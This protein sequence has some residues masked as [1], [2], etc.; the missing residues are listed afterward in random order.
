MVENQTVNYKIRVSKKA[1]HLQLR[2]APGNQ[3]E[4]VLPR[5]I[6]IKEGE[7]FLYN[8]KDW[9]K[10][11]LSKLI[12]QNND[13]QLFGEKLNVIHTHNLFAKNTAVRLDKNKLLIESP[14]ENKISSKQIF[15]VYL[16]NLAKGYIPTRVFELSQKY[17]FKIGR[18]SIRGQ[19]TRWGSCSSKGN[20]SFNFKLMQYKKDVIDYVIVHEL[21]HTKEMNHSPRFWKLV[22]DIIPD[23]KKHKKVL[24][25]DL[26]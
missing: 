6:S 11:H 8:K 9:V 3:L 5:R 25:G 21:C 13:C 2:I 17:N 26:D 15:E 4:L 20:L 23:Y 18:V 1:K 22:G 19:K 7:R 14:S 16:K 10:K 12:S 24:K